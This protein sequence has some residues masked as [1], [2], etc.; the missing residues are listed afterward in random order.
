MVVVS[1]PRW[2]HPGISIKRWLILLVV[3]VTIV[4]LSGGYFAKVL[5]D[6]PFTFPRW[7]YY[8]TLQFWPRGVRGT[9]FLL[10]GGA[11]AGVALLRLNRTVINALFPQ[12]KA[13][14]VDLLYQKRQLKRGPRIVAI[15]GWDGPLHSAL[16]SQALHR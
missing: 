15:G 2:L 1:T 13:R 11:L 3:G 16:W 10:V 7:V 9:L 8:L 14:V 5:Y 4:S 6:A 12:G